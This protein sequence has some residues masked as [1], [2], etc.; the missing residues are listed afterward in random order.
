MKKYN[1]VFLFFLLFAAKIF[2]WENIH[3]HPSISAK[4]IE[5]SIFD[6][7]IQT[8]LGFESSNSELM[9]SYP[10]GILR[11]IDEVEA[12][13]S[14][15]ERSIR[16]WIEVG[17]MIEDA[18]GGEQIGYLFRFNHHFYDPTRNS[19]LNNSEVDFK[20]S[21]RFVG[22]SAVDWALNLNLNEH[23]W[24]ITRRN[25][26][27]A[28]TS[29]LEID[30]EE[31]FARTFL[32]IGHILHMI[33]DMGVP[34]HVRNDSLYAHVRYLIQ[35]DDTMGD[36]K[37]N[38]LENWVE[39]KVK[40]NGDSLGRWISGWSPTPVVFERVADYFD[41]DTRNDISY[42]GGSTDPSSTWGLAEATNYQL[43]SWSTIF[44]E[45]INNTLYFFPHPA[46]IN[47]TTLTEGSGVYRSGYNVEH[48][49]RTTM[50]RDFLMH[51]KLDKSFCLLGKNI[52]DDYA[53]I[54]I[55]RTINYATGLLNYFF[56]GRLS[57]DSNGIDEDG[58]IEIKIK[59][60]SINT[61]SE[62]AL[63][64]GTFELYWDN[65]AN[66][67]TAV[68]GFSVDGWSSSSVLDYDETVLARFPVFTPEDTNI[69]QYV[70]VYK[71]PI[72][73]SSDPDKSDEDDQLAIAVDMFKTNLGN[74]VSICWIDE[75]SDSLSP[76]NSSS[77]YNADLQ[78][79]RNII[80]SNNANIVKGGC[81]VPGNP[82]SGVLPSGYSA[83]EEVSIQTCGRPPSQSELTDD[84]N[85][86]RDGIVPDYLILCVDNSGSMHTADIEPGYG[87]FKTWIRN[88][89]SSTII[90][91]YNFTTERWLNEMK[92][93][94]QNAID[95]LNN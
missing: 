76:Y 10:S 64:G 90:V 92:T 77:T 21:S 7:Y 71:G 36:D 57:V 12:E 58:N 88:N 9:W 15:T 43:L 30:R 41:T 31:S 56:R 40:E 26:Y 25:F 73:P 86:I 80:S 70:L 38:L 59:N 74:V 50:T 51:D 79:Y 29:N 53:E 19:G 27:L 75:A 17:S 35:N 72:N 14:K 60:T 33:E 3:T 93:G 62:Q 18:G 81:L 23:N 1:I 28:L 20:G 44:R 82:P 11:R 89:Y 13:P 5:N 8:Q 22:K 37:I 69:V 94:I 45:N 68:D 67:R 95:N 34:A 2:A 63:V 55:P 78:A 46:F 52:W 6:N 16:E 32:N 42:L 54:T 66:E 91:E 4:C 84:F 83:P 47:T 65:D 48:L 61:D 87:N 49:C 85:R 39:K 24:Q